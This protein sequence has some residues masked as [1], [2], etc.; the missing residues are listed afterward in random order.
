MRFA[1][2]LVPDLPWAARLRAEPELRDAPVAV[3][4]ER[5]A[6]ALVLDASPPALRAGARVGGSL[7]QARAVCAE[8]RVRLASPALERN[9]RQA[10]LDV[11]LSGSPRAELAPPRSGPRAREA[12]V[13]LDASGTHA[14]F[15]SERGLA[16]A[17]VSRA[18][19]LGFAAVAAV[20]SS[21]S[22]ARIFARRLAATEGP[23]SALAVPPAEERAHLAPLPI[24]LLEPSDALADLLTRFGIRHLGALLALPRSTLRSRLGPEAWAWVEA[25]CGTGGELPPPVPRDRRLVEEQELEAPIDRLEPL[26]FVLRGMLDRLLERLSV[27][28]LACPELELSLGLAG[29]GRDERR[30]ALAAPTLD[31]RVLLRRLRVAL[32]A[33]PP[34]QAVER[35]TL[36][37][38]GSPVQGDQLDLFRP[39]GPAP[40]QLDALVAELEALCGPGRVGAPTVPDTHHPEAFALRPFEPGK[41]SDNEG[42]GPRSQAPLALRALRPPLPARVRTQAGRPA[43]VRS[44]LANGEVMRCAGPWRVSGAWWSAQERFAF[45]HFDVLTQDGFLFRLRFDRLRRVWELDGVYD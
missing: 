21:R 27:R 5:G 14:L 1:C 31:P 43:H 23:G 24:D 28:S 10:L 36:S 11:A 34:R 37:T 19:A 20:A 29:G 25:L 15:G 26:A 13:F 9:A 3:T 4:S 8:L 22:S 16:T 40:A 30:L 42:V 33:A 35:V 2:L 38:S 7:A 17:L 41:I 45:E 39:P 44:P 12:S 6:R 32:E 18:Q